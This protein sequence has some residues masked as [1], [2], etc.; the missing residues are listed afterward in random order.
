MN[1]IAEQYVA[2]LKKAYFENQGKESWDH[3]EKIKHGAA[4]ENIRKLRELYPEIPEAL[5][6]LLK[7]V[8]GTYWREYNGEKI[9]FYFLGSDMEEY[10]YYLLSSGEIIEN[11]DLAARYYKDYIEREYDEVDI[12]ETITATVDGLKWLHFSDCMNN[13]GTSQLFI[14][15]SPAEKGTTGQIVRFVHDPDE[16]SVI[17]GS[18]EDYLKM[19]M[20]K[21]Y[22]FINE[23]YME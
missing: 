3:F 2:G 7:Y 4:E 15:F 12:D 6:D 13:G 8:D 14:D 17:A 9:A 18:F 1:P 23:E 22:D 5:I 20:D 10:P 16:F 11:H 21:G 19:L